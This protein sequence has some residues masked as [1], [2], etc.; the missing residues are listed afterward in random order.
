MCVGP[1]CAG[2]CIPDS[3]PLGAPNPDNP[4]VFFDISVGG[5]VIGSIV[6]ELKADVT[7]K[8]CTQLPLPLLLTSWNLRTFVSNVSKVYRWRVYFPQAK[9][10]GRCAQASPRAQQAAFTKARRFIV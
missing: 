1:L 5:S 6:M 8:T 3:P 2:N 10:S 7:P 4:Q 9:T